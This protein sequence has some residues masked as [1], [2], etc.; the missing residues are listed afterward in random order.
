[1]LG[2][3]HGSGDGVVGLKIEECC[4]SIGVFKEQASPGLERKV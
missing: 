3:E 2:L 1:M 4:G